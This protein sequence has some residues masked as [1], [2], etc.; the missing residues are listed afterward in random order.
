MSNNAQLP[1]AVSSAPSAMLGNWL[2][3]P[4]PP[5]QTPVEPRSAQH[6]TMQVLMSTIQDIA[7]HDR[8]DRRFAC[9]CHADVYNALQ[10]PG[11]RARLS[12][13]AVHVSVPCAHVHH[14]AIV[15]LT[16]GNAAGEVS[17]ASHDSPVRS[18]CRSCGKSVILASRSSWVTISGC[19]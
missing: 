1:R 17:F 6:L 2:I 8:D 4:P 13:A 19:S 15:R 14:T 16:T 12:H 5:G 3:W 10:R 11:A 7:I 18:R 9:S